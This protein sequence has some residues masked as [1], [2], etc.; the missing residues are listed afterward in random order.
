MGRVASTGGESPSPG[1]QRARAACAT[2]Y[3]TAYG[4]RPRVP[5]MQEGGA[6]VRARPG[7][8]EGAHQAWT[9]HA[10]SLINPVTPVLACCPFAAFPA[11]PPRW[12]RVLDAVLPEAPA[13]PEACPCLVLLRLPGSSP[14][15]ARGP[16]ALSLAPRK[17]RP[18]V[19]GRASPSRAAAPDSSRDGS[20]DAGPS[21]VSCGTR[22]L[23]IY[24]VSIG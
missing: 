12:N 11:L 19:S 5:A 17:G 21:S 15:R 1:L 2:A 18:A 9:L 24:A 14:S 6:G 10:M 13:W 20:G 23:S 7:R 22:A 16:R 8:R 4:P 3:P